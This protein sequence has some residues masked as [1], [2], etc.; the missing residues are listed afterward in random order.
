MKPLSLPLG[1]LSQEE[2]AR[3]AESHFPA[4]QLARSRSLALSMPLKTLTRALGHANFHC[5][6][7]LETRER[8]GLRF[9]LARGAP[10]APGLLFGLAGACQ[11]GLCA[12][13]A[14]GFAYAGGCLE[15]TR[16]NSEAH[17]GVL[18][19]GHRSGQCLPGEAKEIRP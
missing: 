5:S 1:L 9:G 14:V 2:V 6:I 8:K 4:Q 15:F 11:P 17:P 7:Y 16:L 19:L 13:P 18:G 12:F 10:C 3:T